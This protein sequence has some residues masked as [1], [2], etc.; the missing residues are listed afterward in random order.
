MAN[1]NFSDALKA[2]EASL[3]TINYK[4]DLGSRYIMLFS[5]NGTPSAKVDA[6]TFLSW[7]SGGSSS[8]SSSTS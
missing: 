7:A 1:V 8:S 6:Q 3:S 5:A 2:V 4:S